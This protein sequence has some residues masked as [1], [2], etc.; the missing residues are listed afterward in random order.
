MTTSR[1]RSR[2]SMKLH[3]WKDVARRRI[4]PERRAE[5]DNKV[6]EELASMDLRS[7]REAF[8]MTQEELARIIGVAQGQICRL[9]RREDQRI[10]TLNRYVEALG[11]KLEV[12]AIVRGK[13]VRLTL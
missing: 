4:S 11:G 10:S 2:K 13:R 8:G 1:A 3:K 6:A 12:S 9:E 7:L 5:L